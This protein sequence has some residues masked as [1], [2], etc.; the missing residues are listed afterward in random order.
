MFAAMRLAS[1][2]LSTLAAM[3]ASPPKADIVERG[4][5]VR[6]YARTHALPDF[7]QL[8]NVLSVASVSVGL[9]VG[10]MPALP[11]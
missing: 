3:S 5:H 9:E 7:R 10:I 1:S 4:R 6:F 8:L 2:L 11:I